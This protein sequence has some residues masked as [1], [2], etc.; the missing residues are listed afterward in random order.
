MKTKRIIHYVLSLLTIVGLVYF[1][2]LNTPNPNLN[3]GA[4]KPYAKLLFTGFLWTVVI[5]ILIFTFS[6]ILGFVMFFGHRS[7]VPYIEFIVRHIT[8]IMFGIPMLVVVI[9]GYFFVATAFNV[10]N[11][12]LVGIVILTIYFAP[13]MMKLFISAYESIDHNQIIVSDIFG[14]TKV[15]MYRY[16]LLPQM[17]RIM[18]PPLSGNLA[19]IIKSSSLLYLIGFNELYYNITTVQSRS[20][21]FTEGYLIMLG[22]Y[23]LITI[24]LLKLTDYLEGR[25]KI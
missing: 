11:K 22:A 25:I 13:F 7:K 24:P 21:A 19:N 3:F 8:N 23:L 14:F 18:M 4:Y 17:L 1:V 6:F 10:D 20:F 5:S 16:V 12:L 15:Q 9:I 2:I